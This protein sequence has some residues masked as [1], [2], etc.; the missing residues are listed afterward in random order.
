[1]CDETYKINFENAALSLHTALPKLS[2]IYGVLQKRIY[3]QIYRMTHN[4]EKLF[5]QKLG[6]TYV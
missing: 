4:S 1:M 2:F 3:I 6:R 5:L